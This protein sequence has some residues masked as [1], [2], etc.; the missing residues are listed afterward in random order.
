MVLPVAP[1]PV[2]VPLTLQLAPPPIDS[3]DRTA[4]MFPL[5]TSEGF[6]WTVS[7][8]PVNVSV[9]SAVSMIGLFVTEYEQL[10]GSPMGVGP[11]HP[12]AN[13][14]PCRHVLVARHA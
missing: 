5:V 7:E 10:Y 11:R 9:S 13:P 1:G 8:I 4:R 6:A 3:T 14:M 2:L 12:F